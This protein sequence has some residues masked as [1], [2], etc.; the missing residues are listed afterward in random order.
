MSHIRAVDD[1]TAVMTSLSIRTFSRFRVTKMNFA[2]SHSVICCLRKSDR[3]FDSKLKSSIIKTLINSSKLASCRISGS[4]SCATPNR[5]RRRLLASMTDGTSCLSPWLGGKK[6]PG[7]DPREA[8]VRILSWDVK[9]Y[10]P[11]I[12]QGVAN[13]NGMII[14]GVRRPGA[15]ISHANS[16][17]RKTVTS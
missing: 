10:D 13:L 1:A 6:V 15:V 4:T 17:D 12:T 7:D 14:T 16:R 3:V 8:E 9:C 5:G 11:R 2:S